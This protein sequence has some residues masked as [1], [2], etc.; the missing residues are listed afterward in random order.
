[1]LE[2]LQHDSV[3]V[4]FCS[5]AGKNNARIF[6]LRKYPTSPKRTLNES[7]EYDSKS[8]NFFMI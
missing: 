6:D 1:M 5:L 4:E 3:C 8:F 7:F 2:Y